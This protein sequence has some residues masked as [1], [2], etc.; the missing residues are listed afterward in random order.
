[1]SVIGVVQSHYRE[2]SYCLIFIIMKAFL[3]VKLDN[4]SLRD[5]L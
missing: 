3:H 4:I 2:G 5:F 1:M